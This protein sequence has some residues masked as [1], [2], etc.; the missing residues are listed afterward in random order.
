MSTPIDDA[1]QITGWDPEVVESLYAEYSE[2]TDN[3]NDFL[4]FIAD[5]VGA[6]AFIIAASA[7]MN[8]DQCLAAFEHGVEAVLDDEFDIDSALQ[9]I[10]EA[11]IPIEE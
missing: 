6:C 8:L 3:A 11:A 7:G 2:G 9:S 10:D 1:I 4:A 5:E